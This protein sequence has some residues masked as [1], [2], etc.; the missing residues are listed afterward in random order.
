M[1]QDAL[2]ALNSLQSNVDVVK[3]WIEQRRNNLN[4]DLRKEMEHGTKSLNLDV[5]K[6]T[7]FPKD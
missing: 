2:I 3:A 5:H 4:V 7:S 6:P 1:L